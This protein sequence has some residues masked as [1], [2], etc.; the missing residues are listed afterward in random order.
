MQSY[1]I[2]ILPFCVLCLIGVFT[3]LNTFKSGHPTTDVA[4]RVSVN[5]KI[6]EIAKEVPKDLPI[7]VK[8]QATKKPTEMVNILNEIKKS[9][10]TRIPVDSLAYQ[11]I[12]ALPEDFG[13]YCEDVKLKRLNGQPFGFS[14]EYWKSKPEFEAHLKT[15]TPEAKEGHSGSIMEEQLMLHFLSQGP[16]VKTVCETGFNMGHSSFAYLSSNPNVIVHSFD[17]GEHN[18]SKSMSKYLQS[19]YPNRHFIHFGD[20]TKTIPEYHQ[21]NPDLKCDFIL[22]DG[23]HTGA[24]AWADIYNFATMFG[25]PGKSVMMFDDYPTQWG[26]LTPGKS[27]M[28][29]AWTLAVHYKLIKELM[30]CT[31]RLRFEWNLQR[32]FTIAL[33]TNALNVSNDFKF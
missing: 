20:S 14:A 33:V 7:S 27:G 3:V 1:Q 24:V 25:I 16:G 4:A 12:K 22:V 9:K 11:V 31:S 10:F 17:L 21:Q 23:G 28:G 6:I 32:G 15:L 8:Q 30:R 5:N 13:D 19:K 26:I 29:D 18:Y 2:W